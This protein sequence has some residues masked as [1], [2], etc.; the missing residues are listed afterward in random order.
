MLAVFFSLVDYSMPASE[1]MSEQEQAATLAMSL[2]GD[3]MNTSYALRANARWCLGDLLGAEKDLQVARQAMDVALD[4]ESTYAKNME[5]VCCLMYSKA[6]RWTQ[7][8]YACLWHFCHQLLFFERR[9][10]KCLLHRY[11]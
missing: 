2:G 7:S 4:L 6:H 1:R 10:S 3:L 5:E 8:L 11:L 9:T